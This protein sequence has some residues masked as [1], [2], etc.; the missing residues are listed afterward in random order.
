M[1]GRADWP[2][3]GRTEPGSRW[4]SFTYN[5]V[6]MN[7]PRTASQTSTF[8]VP[9]E[10]GTT[11]LLVSFKKSGGL[12]RQCEALRAGMGLRADGICVCECV[13]LNREATADTSEPCV[14]GFQLL[15]R[16]QQNAIA[17][18]AAAGPLGV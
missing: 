1:A 15:E 7:R 6:T 9:R 12:E 13:W 14:A 8:V 3:G 16:C 11:S 10:A 4:C 17:A 2:A 5:P 18:Q